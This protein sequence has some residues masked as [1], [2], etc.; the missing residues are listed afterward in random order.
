MPRRIKRSNREKLLDITAKLLAIMGLLFVLSLGN[1]W[2]AAEA[3]SAGNAYCPVS[4]DKVDPKVTSSHGGKEYAFC[5]KMCIKDFKKDPEKY[6]ARMQ[7]QG[8]QAGAADQPHGH[9]EHRHHGD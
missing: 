4:G 5:C 7:T 6:I 2:A 9:G 3:V 1:T 8:N